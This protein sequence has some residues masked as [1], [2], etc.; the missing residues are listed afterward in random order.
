MHSA[1]VRELRKGDPHAQRRE[2]GPERQ[3]VLQFELGNV[4]SRNTRI[5]RGNPG[6]PVINGRVGQ[7]TVDAE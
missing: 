7:H 5:E 2:R 1:E 4:E 3:I 6:V